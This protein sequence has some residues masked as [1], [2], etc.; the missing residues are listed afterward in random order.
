[1]LHFPHH[2]GLCCTF[3]YLE[4]N[5][6]VHPKQILHLNSPH[7]PHKLT[8][9]SVQ[10]NVVKKKNNVFLFIM[11]NKSPHPRKFSLFLICILEC[12]RKKKKKQAVRSLTSVLP[13]S[14]ILYSVPTKGQ[15]GQD[16]HSNTGRW[17][18]RHLQ[19]FTAATALSRGTFLR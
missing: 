16:T 17:T 10:A 19:R 6:N 18:A 1:M 5:K 15:T 2:S 14:P 13:P 9:L 11:M 3:F 8:T 4:T 7:L 12:E